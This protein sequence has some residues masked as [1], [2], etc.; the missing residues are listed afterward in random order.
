[1]RLILGLALAIFGAGTA[2]GLGATSLSVAH[3]PPT[4]PGV[5]RY[6]EALR[7][8][9]GKQIWASYSPAFRERRIREGDSEAAT[10]A[11]F[12]TLRQRGASIDEETYVGGYQ[13]QESGYFLCVTRHYRPKQAPIEVVWIFQTDEASL[14]DRIVV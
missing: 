5:V 4:P 2:A 1:M 10:I 8:D 13:A 11:L 12:E 3:P 6:M 7:R 9:D 14:I